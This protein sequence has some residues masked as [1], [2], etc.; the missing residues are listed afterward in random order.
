MPDLSATNNYKTLFDKNWRILTVIVAIALQWGSTTA[1]LRSQAD[2]LNNI[3]KRIEN[4]NQRI[5][6]AFNRSIIR[7]AR[8]DERRI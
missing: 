1:T 3:D 7:A 6:N 2:R 8:G 4:I 5:D